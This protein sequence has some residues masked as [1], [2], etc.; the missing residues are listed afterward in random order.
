M[1]VLVSYPE[2]D[3][4]EKVC[5]D[6]KTYLE[7]FT[8]PY[9]IIIISDH[10]SDLYNTIDTYLDKACTIRPGPDE[11]GFYQNKNI[12]KIFSVDKRYITDGETKETYIKKMV[13]LYQPK[14]NGIVIF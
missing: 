4:I 12:I 1:K 11:Y 8:D 9:E 3:E 10:K 7:T 5:K 13:K 14:N 2:K 6:I